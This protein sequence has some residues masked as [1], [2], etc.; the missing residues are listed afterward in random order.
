MNPT[1]IGIIAQ[2]ALLAQQQLQLFE[3]LRDSD[4][5]AWAAVQASYADGAQALQLAMAAGGPVTTT[6]GQAVP[7][8]D[9]AAQAAFA[10]AQ[11]GVSHV[12]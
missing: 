11:S 9:E 7:I 2:L 1:T 10:A 5:E 6:Q 8:S 4:P 12:S 3:K